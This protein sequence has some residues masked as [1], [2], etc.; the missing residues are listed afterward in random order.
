ML[1]AQ[2]RQQSVTL[3]GSLT[4][5]SKIYHHSKDS[6]PAIRNQYFSIDEIWGFGID[7]RFPLSDGQTELGF[8][9]EYLS[10]HTNKINLL[11]PSNQGKIVDGYYAIPIEAS[12]YFKLPIGIQSLTFYIGGGIGLYFG[13]RDLSIDGIEN[14]INHFSP[15]AGIHILTGCEYKLTS[16]FSARTEIK[17]REVQFSS[18]SDKI[19]LANNSTLPFSIESSDS[20]VSIDG[21]LL[22]LGIVIKW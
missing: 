6:D 10:A 21:L 4:T 5:T 9:I 19:E 1:P 7:Y 22:S 12:S 18:E 11:D 16:I 13:G 8:S 20:R 15:G 17:F 3:S 2:N 14:H